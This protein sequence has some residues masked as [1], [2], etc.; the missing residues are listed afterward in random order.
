MDRAGL[1]LGSRQAVRSR[2]LR[3]RA[4][5]PPGII[6]PA[7]RTPAGPM[8]HS[9]R[10]P[11]HRPLKAEIIGSNPICG[12][13]SPTPTPPDRAP[14]AFS[15]SGPA[16]ATPAQAT[17]GGQR[18]I[19]PASITARSARE[20]S[21]ASGGRADR[22]A[23]DGQC[24]TTR[25]NLARRPVR[26]V[27]GRPRLDTR[28]RPVRPGHTHRPDTRR[29][30][31]RPGHTHRPDTRHRPVRPGHTHRPDTRHNRVWRSARSRRRRE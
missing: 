17:P 19:L 27:R 14:G 6:P 23:G 22:H 16:G 28:R 20:G 2:R 31:V 10:G 30:P 7:R 9:S 8:P 1:R 29:R 5:L 25:S 21:L 12:T 4:V 26:P 11:G 3:W 24:P 18:P 13:K 15:I